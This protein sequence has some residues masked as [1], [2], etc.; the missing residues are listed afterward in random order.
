MDFMQFII[1]EGLII[2]AGL[3]VIGV[4]IKGIPNIP[5]WIIPFVLVAL[6]VLAAGFSMEGGFTIANILQGIFAAG[7]AVLVNQGIKQV[8][9]RDGD[10]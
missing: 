5:N 1:Q 6:G 4:I 9:E 8:S 3:Y 2:A 7:A 10:E